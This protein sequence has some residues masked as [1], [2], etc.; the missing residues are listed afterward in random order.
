MGGSTH[1]RR[2]RSRSLANVAQCRKP[3]KWRNLVSKTSGKKFYALGV[4][5]LCVAQAVTVII[6]GLIRVFKDMPCA[7]FGGLL[8][9][10]TGYLVFWTLKSLKHINKSK[11][12]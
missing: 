2:N 3:G 6:E 1:L 10:P 7:G 8:L 11:R 9:A 4:F 5:I 12:R